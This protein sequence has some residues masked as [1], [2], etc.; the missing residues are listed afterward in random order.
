M[1]F[2][3]SGNRK[4]WEERPS[5]LCFS[6]VLE[7]LGGPGVCSS[8]LPLSKLRGGMRNGMVG[9]GGSGLGAVSPLPRSWGRSPAGFA[10]RLSAGHFLILVPDSVTKA[11][12]DSLGC[13]RIFHTDSY[14]NSGSCSLTGLYKYSL[15][16]PELGIPALGLQLLMTLW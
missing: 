3:D 16:H 10:R 4:L 7:T 9:L 8:G 14:A 11:A 15:C 12:G 13:N 2:N 6:C 5:P 1:T